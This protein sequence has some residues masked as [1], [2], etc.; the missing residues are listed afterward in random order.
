M[1][2][3]AIG[4]HQEILEKKTPKAY[5]AFLSGM[6]KAGFKLSAP[7][8]AA[9]YTR[10]GVILKERE[11]QARQAPPPGAEGPPQSS[12]LARTTSQQDEDDWDPQ[13]GP[14]PLKEENDEEE[15]DQEDPEEEEPQFMPFLNAKEC[16]FFPFRDDETLDEFEERIAQ[17]VTVVQPDEQAAAIEYSTKRAIPT[18]HA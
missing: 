3:V 6:K 1:L 10:T 5:N 8:A 12:A 4:V 14:P 17:G 16:F 18:L 2:E 9:L 15:E 13:E 7:D 11:K